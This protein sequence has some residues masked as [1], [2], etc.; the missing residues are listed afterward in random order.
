MKGR[1]RAIANYTNVGTVLQTP[2]GE[3]GGGGGGGGGAG[4]LTG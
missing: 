4:L 2:L 1:E 3:G